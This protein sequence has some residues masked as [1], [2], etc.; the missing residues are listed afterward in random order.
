MHSLKKQMHTKLIPWTILQ[1]PN[2]ANQ[3]PN[4]LGIILVLREY[5]NK[6]NSHLEKIL[7]RVKDNNLCL[8]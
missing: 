8:L 3:F 1:I 5:Y 6:V 7:C 2:I 4:K